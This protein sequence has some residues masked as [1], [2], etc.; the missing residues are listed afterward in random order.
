MSNLYLTM[1]LTQRV[2]LFREKY[3][4]SYIV[5]FYIGLPNMKVLKA[6]F[7]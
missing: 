6:V 2:A 5:K 1:K 3:L 7:S 4:H